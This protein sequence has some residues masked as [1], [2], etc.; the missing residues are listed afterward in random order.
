MNDRPS[1]LAVVSRFKWSHIDY[2]VALSREVELTVAWSGVGHSGAA[3]RAAVDGLRM[4]PIG[5]LATDGEAAVRSALGSLIG[6]SAPDLIHVM[7]YYHEELTLLLRD[8][9]PDVPIVWECRDPL[10]TLKGAAPGSALWQVESSAIVAADGHI[11]VSEALRD[12]LALSHGA[13]LRDALIVPHA[14][15]SRNA[16]PLRAKLSSQDGRT[17]IALVGTADDARGH[18]RYYVDIIRRLVA[19]GLVVHSHFHEEIEGISLDPYREL[20]LELAD[21]HHR[22]TV[23]FRKDH[24]LSD[25]MSRYDLM[26]VFHEL[27]APEHNEAAT[28]EVCMPTKAASA[29]LHGAI[30]VVTFRHYRGLV[31][32]I[33]RLGIG[34][35][36]DDWSAVGR[37]VGARAAIDEATAACVR[38]RELFT[39]EHQARRVADY[40]QHVIEGGRQ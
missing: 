18:G 7:Y 40:Y 32:V 27:E 16:G 23:P 14:F 3:Q 20:D 8:M 35:I 11:L 4:T 34:F 6:Q 17:H 22:P 24:G 5:A 13:E 30:P 29:W 31:E 37:L 25:L 15:A 36:V 10:T 12:Y 9:C 38:H 26:G 28:L 21:Y 19:E 33:E 2:L 39:H 1:V